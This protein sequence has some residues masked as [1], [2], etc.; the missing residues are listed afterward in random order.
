LRIGRFFPLKVGINEKNV[1][2]NIADLKEKELLETIGPD[3][4]GY[5]KI[6]KK[7]KTKRE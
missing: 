7:N 5:W 1:R 2:N 4:G 3:K 6:A